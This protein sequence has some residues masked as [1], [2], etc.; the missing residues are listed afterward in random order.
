MF[1]G[2]NYYYFNRALTHTTINAYVGNFLKS[3]EIKTRIDIPLMGRFY[4]EPNVIYNEWDFLDNKDLLTG[5]KDPTILKRFDSSVGLNMSFPVSREFKLSLYSN[6]LLNSDR[7][8]NQEVL[9]STDTVDLLKLSGWKTGLLFETNNLNRKQYANA[10]K[11]MFLKFDWFSVSENYEPGNTSLVP[12]KND[13]YGWVRLKISAEQYLRTGV[14]SSGYFLEGVFSNQPTFSNYMGTIINAPAFLPMQDGRTL[15]LERFRSF[16][17]VAGG[18]RNI[19]SLKSNLDLRLEGYAFKPIEAI[20]PSATQEAR[21]SGDLTRISFAGM[22]SLVLHTTVGPI[23]LSFNYYDDRQN[24]FG[25][26]LHI[27]YLLFPKTSLE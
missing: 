21:L 3:A 22:A 10:G 8:S 1:L 13:H 6:Y 15:L 4:L 16:N 24:Q 26:L 19:F 25:G 11:H 2:V 17:Y 9:V 14:Y 23:S 18:I 20:L 7:Y 12:A 27:G 5:R